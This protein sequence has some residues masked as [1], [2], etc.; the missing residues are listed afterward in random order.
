[1][2]LPIS[3]PR[4]LVSVV[5]SRTI[6]VK[7]HGRIDRTTT[8]L[9][10]LVQ[11]LICE[12]KFTF[13]QKTHTV[14]A[15]FIHCLHIFITKTNLIA[16]RT[17]PNIGNTVVSV[18][19]SSLMDG[20]NWVVSVHGASFHGRYG[21]FRAHSNHENYRQRCHNKWPPLQSK[22]IIKILIFFYEYSFLIHNTTKKYS[23]WL[24]LEIKMN[25][26]FPF[27]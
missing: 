15:F 27:V 9:S 26:N 16:P 19:L 12:Y 3:Y 10:S 6:L 23:Y 18:V 14:T 1:M 17:I 25:I 24:I 4:M 2:I 5:P 21:S 20:N 13:M 11:S 8:P 22:N 7:V